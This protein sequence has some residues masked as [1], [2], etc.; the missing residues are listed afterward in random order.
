MFVGC[1]SVVV[2]N[3]INVDGPSRAGLVLDDVVLVE[4]DVPADGDNARVQQNPVALAA[5]VVAHHDAWLADIVKL[6]PFLL[7]YM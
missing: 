5:G 7:G 1:S 6:V 3:I 2:R 4:D